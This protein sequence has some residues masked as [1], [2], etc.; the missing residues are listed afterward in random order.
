TSGMLAAPMLYHDPAKQFF[1]A[2]FPPEV[3]ATPQEQEQFIGA[4]TQFVMRDLPP[5]APKGYLLTPRR[6][7]SLT[8]MLDTILEGEGI[9]RAALEAQRKRTELLGRLLQAGDDEQALK[10]LVEANRAELDYEFFLTLAAYIEAAEQDQDAESVR[11][12][13]ELRDR[14]M[15]WTGFD[16]QAEGLAEPDI[17]QAIEALLNVEEARLPETIAEYRP[18]LDYEFY[19]ALADQIDTARSAGETAEAARLEA[20]R[21]L[22][23]DTV[24]KMDR[25][26]QALF[27]G[28]A[29]TLQEVLEA[30]DPRAA[31]VEHR[32]QLNEAF[33]LVVGANAQQAQ[34]TGNRELA[35]RLAEIER[36]AVEVVQES[37]SPAERLIGQLLAAEKP[38][39]A[40]RL[41]RQNAAM[42]NTDF[43]KRLNELADETDE[44]GRKEIAERL[45]QL[46]REAASMLF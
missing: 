8:S 37:L 31:L 12:F 7:I 38:Q 40:T 3:K 36:L 45:R 26:A 18:V 24:E 35:D 28:A 15:E 44:A 25:D 43:V 32:E 19:S 11:R 5:D 46:G 29:Q 20:R 27:E 42:I 30:D 16:A 14:A 23:R 22:I 33:L 13:T 9:P 34:R 21:D 1:F 4:L 6:F 39:D 17:T 41:L 2:L 10:Q